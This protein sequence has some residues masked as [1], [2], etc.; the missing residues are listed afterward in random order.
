M[1]KLKFEKLVPLF[2]ANEEFSL[3][4]TQYKNNVGQDLPKDFYYLKNKSAL[5]RTAKEYG[6]FIEINEKTICLKKAN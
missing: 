5:A 6:F 1:A 2:E 3:T 4:E